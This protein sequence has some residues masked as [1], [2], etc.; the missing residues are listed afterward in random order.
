MSDKE[1][2][3]GQCAEEYA[4]LGLPIIMVKRKAKEAAQLDWPN[5]A[6]TNPE[7][8]RKL[9]S[10]KNKTFNVG[11]VMGERAGIIDIETD[12]HGGPDGEESL[13]QFMNQAG[14]CLPITWAFQSGS[15]GIH[16]L[17]RCD[18]PISKAEAILPA[19]DVRANG[20]YAVVPPSIHP[21]GNHYKWLEG[22]NPTALPDGPADL[23]PCLLELLTEKT[24]KANNT[25]F[26]LPDMI[27]QG[28]RD[29]TLFKMAA[30]LRA[31][32]YAEEEIISI[33]KAV[34]NRRCDPP[35]TDKQLEKICKSVGKYEPGVSRSERSKRVKVPE[36]N[37]HSARDL[38]EK[39]LPPIRWIVVDLIPQGL[40]LLA[41]P[42]KYGKSWWVLDLCLSVARGDR[43]MNRTTEKSG[44]LYLALEDSENRLQ[45]RINRLTYGDK[46]PLGFDY[47]ITAA[48]LD[49]GLIEQLEAYL[50]KRPNTSLIV[51]DTL[52]KVKG[53]AT[54]NESAYADDYRQMT[55]LKRFADDHGICV[56]LVHH[57]KKGKGEGDVFERISGTNGIFGSADTAIVMQKEKR[58]DKETTLH[59]TGRDVVADDEV[60]EFNK[61][62]CRWECK[63]S[64]DEIEQRRL[65][66]EYDNDPIVC[67]IKKLLEDAPI[68]K[69]T[70]SDLF[71]AC[72]E[73][74][75]IPPAEDEK[76]LGKKIRAV[77]NMMWVRDDVLYKAPGKN[78]GANGRVHSFQ[79]KIK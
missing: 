34:N 67:T 16:R 56:L 59:I 36:L 14:D 68:W 20:S 74:T 5:V 52:Q 79:K 64:V 70:A 37:V 3:L 63:G 32:E 38:Q 78:G 30:S 13:K 7:A 65:T 61:D 33:L 62:S 44:C 18:R 72:L 55:L 77:A 17:F 57:L 1:S 39:D 9:W 26:E 11:V 27:P 51:V 69:G 29:S 58:S 45:D 23:P 10:G 4:S 49:T 42:P 19:V 76:A 53:Q 60:I 8:A 40:T 35:L 73:I 12:N 48:T 66:L 28:E 47:T 46:A 22:Q 24:D 50:K 2:I 15:G 6:T 71:T 41:S 25:P 21:N 54:K 31:Q 75:G 43:F